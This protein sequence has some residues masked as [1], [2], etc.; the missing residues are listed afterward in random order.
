[1]KKI[2]NG[3]RYDTSKAKEVA[4]AYSVAPANDFNYW[5]ETLYQKRTGEFFLYGHGGPMSKY[6]VASGNN[7][8]GWGEKI[9]PLTVDSAVKWAE[10]YMDA[11]DYEELFGA[12]SE[13][14]SKK[15]VAY[16][17]PVS[18]ID[19]V[20]RISAERGVPFSDVVAEAIEAIK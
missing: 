12:P 5:E 2:I 1:M 19:K 20:K 7:T 13:D 11:D 3:K 10:T 9:F 14:D 15:V 8:W 6:A 4:T 16:S 17:L 18:L